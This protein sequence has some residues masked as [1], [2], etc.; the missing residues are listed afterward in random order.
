L[1]VGLT[2]AGVLL[3][4]AALL[5]LAP[6]AWL[7]GVVP[8]DTHGTA[9]NLSLLAEARAALA[10]L[11]LLCLTFGVFP[12][13]IQR[14]ATRLAPWLTAADAW[15]RVGRRWST[16]VLASAAAVA[17]VF[18]SYSLARHAAFNSKAY[19][20]GLHAQVIW[21]TSQGRLFA[22]SIEVTNYLGDHVSPIIVL[23]APLYRL[24]P[25]P[26]GLLI[27]Q[28]IVLA[29]GAL[30]LAWMARH[31]LEAAWRGG[32]FVA[33][34]ILALIFLA[35]PALGFVNRFEF[36]EETLVVPLLLTAF[37]CLEAKRPGWM[38]IALL[39][40]LL[41]KEDIGLTVAA[42]G[43]FAAWRLPERRWIGLA[44]AGLGAAWSLA[45]LFV[46][47]PAFRG[48]PSDTLGRYAWLGAGPSDILQTLFRDPGLAIQHVVG[49]PRR[50]WMLV[51]ALLPT[52]FLALLSPTIL[53]ALP[54]LAINW[55]AGNLYQSSIYFHYIA[56]LV[57]IVF[58]STVFGLARAGG[59]RV[60]GGEWRGESGGWRVE[61]RKWRVESGGWR[62]VGG[63]S[64]VPP[65]STLHPLPSLLLLWLIACAALAIAFDQF[66]QPA[67]GPTDWE[68]YSLQR[69]LD[70]VAF[71]EAAALLPEDGS[72]ATTEAF[73]P[74]LAERQGLYL[75][76]DPRIL[77]VVDQVDWVLVDLNDHRYG[78]EPRRYYGLLRWIVERRQLSTCY[79]TGR[80][81]LLGPQCDNPEAQQTYQA[82]LR[83]LQWSVADMPLDP[84][85]IE[86]LGR[87]FFLP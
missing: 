58:A 54:G 59:R 73:A 62:V 87:R 63:E 41:C 25:D 75:L 33:S 9:F 51:K 8:L 70:P 48:A 21:N 83:E 50:L 11:G 85:L 10:L 34:L 65:P 55:L 56:P 45:A 29:S 40:A 28:A 30:P 1:R 77:Q 66:W 67:T 3:L 39:L 68:N 2:G 6:D 69:T 76:H 49:E 36:H 46:V 44:W 32:G 81:V 12:Q 26:R 14:L 5:V 31:R 19:D 38:S 24:W 52:G 27:L 20:L 74:H 35:Y 43:V 42:F 47:V 17:T 82:T 61:G 64:G 37:G 16:L 60:E 4:G 78:V 18:A 57:P 80:V 86:A 71:A 84:V 72:L 79:F 15:L 23:L 53:I 22:S 13:A 7:A